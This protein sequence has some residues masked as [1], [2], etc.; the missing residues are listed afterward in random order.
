MEQKKGFAG[1]AALWKGKSET[2]RSRSIDPRHGRRRA[3]CGRC[4]GGFEG[5]PGLL[6]FC[7]NLSRSPTLSRLSSPFPTLSR[8]ILKNA[9]KLAITLLRRF[10]FIKTT[11]VV[12][13]RVSSSRRTRRQ[14]KDQHSNIIEK[15]GG[16]RR[17]E[18]EGVTVHDNLRRLSATCTPPSYLGK[19]YI[20]RLR[21]DSQ[22]LTTGLFLGIHFP[23][24]NPRNLDKQERRKAAPEN[25]RSAA[26][27]HM[28]Q[29]L[30]RSSQP[31]QRKM[32]NEDDG[33]G[34]YET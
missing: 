21:S 6:R 16:G 34:V 24:S 31:R 14:E 5:W 25:R 30:E 2:M 17:N 8:K 1:N 15:S 29:T 18:Q 9:R 23:G 28:F 20:T 11:Q 32:R 26:R 33:V 27:A 10:A 3:L 12:R 13:W 22:G 7:K 4:V 19:M